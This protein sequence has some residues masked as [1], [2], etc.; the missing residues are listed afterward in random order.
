M[1]TASTYGLDKHNLTDLTSVTW[2]ASAPQL[3]E[4]AI[5]AKEG[6]ES[7]DSAFVV[8][9]GV[10]TGRSSNDRFVV[11]NNTSETTVHWGDV[12]V[13]MTQEHFDALYVDIITHYKSQNA[14]VQDC[15]TGADKNHQ[16]AVRVITETAWHSLFARNMFIQTEAGD[17]GNFIPQITVIHAP[18][19]RAN[20]EKH[21]T[22][23]STAIAIDLEKNIV[24]IAGTS[25]AGEIKKSVFSIMNYIMP[26]EGILPMH[27]SA[28]TDE[29]GNTAIFFGLSGTGKT[30]LSADASRTLIG[31]DEHGWSDNSVFNF[32][33]G[34]YAKVINLSAEDEPE[35][36]ATT[37]RFGTVLEN[38]VMDEEGHLDLND[39]SLTE[40]TRASYPIE[41]IPNASETG[42]SNQPKN[43]I[44]LTADA[45]GVLPPVSKL[46]AEQA[47]YHF[48]SGYTAKVAGTEKGL[49]NEPVACFSACF[50]LPFMPRNPKVYAEMLK[51]K[52]SKENVHCWLVNTGWTGGAYGTG[53]RM[54]IKYTRAMIN[55]ALSGELAKVE[56]TT[57]EF[58]GLHIPVSC[59]G[60]PSEVLDPQ[61]TWK[62]KKAYA[63]A[64]HKVLGMFAENFTQFEDIKVPVAA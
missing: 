5:K 55:A 29:N 17:L 4:A 16:K 41:Y 39:N 22:N 64:A 35:I 21:G 32:E 25:Y 27:A 54:P 30:T 58:F 26:E 47:M 60:V 2:N 24:L 31:D 14:F 61:S 62:D 56:T 50:G 23:S 52:I 3:Y 63:E 34:C 6:R 40:N 48:L 28:N 9:T 53:E 20:P 12:N 13:P 15:F 45:F 36:Y 46:T 8:T 49:G 59:P 38:V 10:H 51:D 42:V 37:K 57:D 44:M 11:R 43:V 18:S 33:G 19:M 7:A 1:G